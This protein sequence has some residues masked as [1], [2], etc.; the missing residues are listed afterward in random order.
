M[1]TGTTWK[2]FCPP[3]TTNILAEFFHPNQKKKE[4]NSIKE[5]KKK[6]IIDKFLTLYY[7]YINSD[8]TSIESFVKAGNYDRT[9]NTLVS[10]WKLYVPGYAETLKSKKRNIKERNIAG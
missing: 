3:F 4:K 7:N 5:K 6:E 10:Y 8:F 1:A 9:Y 2:I